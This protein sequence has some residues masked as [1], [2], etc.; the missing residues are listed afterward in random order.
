MLVCSCIVE[1]YTEFFRKV[2]FDCISVNFKGIKLRA[3][4]KN[5][6]GCKLCNEVFCRSVEERSVFFKI[7]KVIVG[8]VKRNTFCKFDGEIINRKTRF[9]NFAFNGKFKIFHAI[10]FNKRVCNSTEENL[11]VCSCIVESYTEFFRKVNFNRVS[12]YFEGIKL[13]ALGED[14]N[15]HKLGNKSFCHSVENGFVFIDVG[16]VVV[17]N[18]KCNAL[19]KF[20]GRI[21]NVKPCFKNFAFNCKEEIF[22]SVAIDYR[23]CEGCEENPFSCSC[24]VESYTEFFRKVDDCRV[25][26]NF[27]A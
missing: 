12:V 23:V 8:N 26:F 21:V 11:L 20:D 6:N 25:I 19:S 16:K 13:R 22:S 3:L 24:I 18:V 10:K 14:S 2:N 1:S 15:C 27:K 7:R 4:G 17:G 5:A 9:K